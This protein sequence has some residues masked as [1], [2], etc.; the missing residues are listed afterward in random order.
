M[1]KPTDFTSACVDPIS[2]G[3]WEQTAE[4]GINARNGAPAHKNYKDYVS[5]VGSRT[6]LTLVPNGQGG[7]IQIATDGS[8]WNSKDWK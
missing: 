4:G 8:H 5:Q 3:F 6:F 2:G 7:F 1:P